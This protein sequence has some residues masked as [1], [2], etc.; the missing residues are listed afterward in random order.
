MVAA[1]AEFVDVA[2][3]AHDGGHKRSGETQRSKSALRKSFVML[4]QGVISQFVGIRVEE[5]Q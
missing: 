3:G 2:V 4:S 1:L 5:P